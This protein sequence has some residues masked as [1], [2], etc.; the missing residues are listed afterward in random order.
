MATECRLARG[1]QHASADA[2]SAT[3]KAKCMDSIVA[4]IAH[5]PDEASC[6]ASA[7]LAAAT[8]QEGAPCRN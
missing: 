4:P 6:M 5:M 3:S 1:N 7:S 2:K 8:Q